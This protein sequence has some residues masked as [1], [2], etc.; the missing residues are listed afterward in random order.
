MHF[1]TRIPLQ[2]LDV[3]CLNVGHFT[4]RTPMAL[5]ALFANYNVKIV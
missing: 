3:E 5:K 2:P 4:D 1:F